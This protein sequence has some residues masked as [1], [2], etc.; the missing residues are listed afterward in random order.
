MRKHALVVGINRYEDLANI[1]PLQFAE[2]DAGRV[3]HF[4][5]ER[6]GFTVSE[7]IGSAAG[8]QAICDA[9][10]KL[11][12]GLAPGDLFVCYFSGH[13][14]EDSHG[15]LFLLAA[16][17]RMQDLKDGAYGDTVP[18]RFLESAT[19]PCG[20]SRVLLLDVCRAP[21]ESEGGVVELTPTVVQ[22]TTSLCQTASS[23]NPPLAI[24]YSC[25]EHQK[26]YG[27]TDPEVNGG[28]FSFSLLQALNDHLKAGRE[29]VLPADL[30]EVSE[31]CRRVLERH[32]FGC[33]QGPWCAAN[34]DRVVLLEA[35]SFA[36][37]EEFEGKKRDVAVTGTSRRPAAEKQEKGV[38]ETSWKQRLPLHRAL[39]QKQGEDERKRAEAQETA[40]IAAEQ[41]RLRQEALQRQ[42]LKKK[43][44]QW[45]L[46]IALVLV[47]ALAAWFAPWPQKSA[48]QREQAKS[49]T[50]APPQVRPI[51]SKM[52]F[53]SIPPGEFV[54]GCS[55]ADDSCYADEGPAHS[56]TITK[57]FEMGKYEVTQA[58]W[59]STMGS[60]PSHFKGPDRPAENVS[61]AEAQQFL[62]KLNERGDGYRYRL[63]TETE[64]EYAARA[65]TTRSQLGGLD[66]YSWYEG[67]AGG[68]TH[69]VGQKQ[70][71]AWGLYDVHGN[72]WEWVA[73]WYGNYS[74][75]KQSKG[76][77][78]PS[79]ESFKIGRVVRGGSWVTLT[80][81]VRLSVR[82]SFTPDN[83]S[84]NIGLRILREKNP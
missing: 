47:G 75:G 3:A 28:A 4:L 18:L 66:E 53:A 45:V 9:Q 26:A 1:N 8:R 16:D 42:Q 61:W 79:S 84:N 17:V 24:V 14:Y 65:G 38:H 20:A 43:L 52:E 30:K 54:M 60:N 46:G 36:L 40:R 55:P 35:A 23:E 15:Y 80:Y 11:C 49:G 41:E 25:S 51:T 29:L 6:C 67:N 19:A 62:E 81:E 34:R 39:H 44:T 82:F 48:T 27:I 83:R 12:S 7:L 76:R 37:P 59:L 21:L 63:P 33:R 13:A 64:W 72:V 22:N 31:N 5:R 69:P 70:P 71:N 32:L 58:Q 74:L 57:R 78:D 68:Q 50:T 73:D 2:Q 56:V 77:T 10:E